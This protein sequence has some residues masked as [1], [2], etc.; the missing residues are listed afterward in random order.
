MNNL[1]DKPWKTPAEDYWWLRSQIH[2]LELE[3][4]KLRNRE[5]DLERENAAL[6]AFANDIIAV[7]DPDRSDIQDAGVKHGLLENVTATEPCGYA[8]ACAELGFPAEC[9]RKTKALDA[10]GKERV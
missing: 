5:I 2:A 8:C 6:R 10:G 7:D 3:T 4:A 1:Q 9:Y